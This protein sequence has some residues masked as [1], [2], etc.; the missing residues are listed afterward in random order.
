M[1]G[2]GSGSYGRATGYPKAENFRQYDLAALSRRGYLDSI[3]HVLTFPTS[4]RGPQSVG[5]LA[6]PTGVIFYFKRQGEIHELR[7]PYAYTATAF[8]GQRKWFACPQCGKACRVLYGAQRLACRHCHGLRYASQSE[9]SHWRARRKAETIRCRV[10][11]SQDT[12]QPFPPKPPRM[13]WVTYRRLQNA[14]AALS[15]QWTVGMERVLAAL[16]ETIEPKR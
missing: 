15:K 1:G 3:P 5:M 9:S 16:K 14:D 13:R 11:G 8:G 7:I 4:A 12:D 2:F 6:T 10:G